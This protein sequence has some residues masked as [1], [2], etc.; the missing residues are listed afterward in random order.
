MHFIDLFGAEKTNIF[1]GGHRTPIQTQGVE[2]LP[3]LPFQIYMAID[4]QPRLASWVT[5]NYWV[6]VVFTDIGA[7]HI[8]G[9]QGSRIYMKC[10]Y[11]FVRMLS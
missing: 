1:Y 4:L 2:K 3:W 10:E 6:Y 11:V 7:K 8:D 5:I 9:R